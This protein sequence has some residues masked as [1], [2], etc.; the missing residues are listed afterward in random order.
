MSNI[1]PAKVKKAPFAS[2]CF[3]GLGQILF[4]RQF[5]R[6][7]ILMLFEL[8]MLCFVVFGTKKIIPADNAENEYMH[9]TPD[10]VAMIAYLAEHEYAQLNDMLVAREKKAER[11][12]RTHLA[13]WTKK[14]TRHYNKR[15]AA[16]GE[17]VQ[18]FFDE[19]VPLYA[20]AIDYSDPYAVEDAVFEIADAVEIAVADFQLARDED[21]SYEDVV[22]ADGEKFIDRFIAMTEK[23][24]RALSKAMANMAIANGEAELFDKHYDGCALCKRA[25]ASGR[26]TLGHRAWFRGPIVAALAGLVTLGSVQP[27]T[28]I[29]YADHSIFMMING[30]LVIII[31]AIFFVTY[32][33]NIIYAKKDA[34]KIIKNN[35][36][37]TFSES[38][39][40]IAQNSFAVIGI[41][42][43]I[44]MIAFFTVIPLLFSALVAF[45]NYSS[46]D[47]IPPNNLVDWVG[48]ENFVTMF[49][50]KGSSSGQWFSTFG[51][52]A[53]WTV[54]WAVCSTFTC[55]FAGFFFAVIL[56]DKRIKIPKLYR[57][58]FILPYAIPT[59]LSLFI[60]AN[61]LNGTFG[62]INRTL[63]Y[64]QF[65]AEGIPWLSNPVMAKFSLILV[66]IWIGFPYSM[67]LIT[68]SMTAISNSVYEAATIDGA[69]KWMQFRSITFPLV[70]FQLKPILIMQFAA[71]INNFG[72]VFFLTSGGPNLPDTISTQAGA[73]DILI[74]WI[75]K[76]TM[77]T[78]NMYN[79]ASVLS[80]LVFVVLVPFALYNFMRT[81]SFKEGEV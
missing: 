25:A 62:P 3:M 14:I 69:N 22:V 12:L 49:S 15:D 32:A 40:D 27:T 60:W 66:N 45:T 59:M 55:F 17:E 57:T 47:H 46:P 21:D 8:V 9:G 50:S 2:A 56:Q 36:F 70:M 75:Y 73:T 37:P 76:L 35:K 26:R 5:I 7:A 80:I 72:A 41:A 81:K 58:I 33:F 18:T 13:S 54:V 53:L 24:D 79:L 11:Y 10:A 77:N 20:D 39:N 48:L 38:R 52:V 44:I 28:V 61:L 67:I 42:P 30:L 16:L 51:R 68:S 31:L 6:G 43:C 65:I 63:M 78:P 1:N 74:S 4:L 71:N 19:F 34:E 29:K 64:F 23:S